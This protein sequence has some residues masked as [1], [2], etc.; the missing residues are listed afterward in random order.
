PEQHPQ[1]V[2]HQPFNQIRHAR[3]NERSRHKKRRLKRPG[4]GGACQWTIDAD[5]IAANIELETLPPNWGTGTACARPVDP[6]AIEGKFSDFPRDRT[7]WNIRD[8]TDPNAKAYF[9]QEMEVEVPLYRQVLHAYDSDGFGNLLGEVA[10]RGAVLE[11]KEFG[12]VTF[13]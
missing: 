5:G 1:L 12:K 13:G 4:P 7:R 2:R 9:K 6:D 10:E 3:I 11:P 8:V